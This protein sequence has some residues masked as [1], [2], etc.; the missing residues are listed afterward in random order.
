VICY[1][2]TKHFGNKIPVD[3]GALD[4]HEIHFGELYAKDHARHH[5]N[6]SNQLAKYAVDPNKCMLY[7]VAVPD[8]DELRELFYESLG[9]APALSDSALTPVATDE[10][11]R[12]E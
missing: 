5:G 7:L 4:K 11:D 10:D 8:V 6:V 1:S 3:D 12:D 2:E 9:I